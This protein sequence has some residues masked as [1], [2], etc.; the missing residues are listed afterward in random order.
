MA[1]DLQTTLERITS[2]AE[3]LVEKYN[4]LESSKQAVEQENASLKERVASLERQIEKLEREYE[5]LQLARTVSPTR[6]DIRKNQAMLA[7]L[8]QDIDKCISQLME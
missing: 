7:E 2:K 5:Y 1:S 4:A 3:V 6:E 8:V